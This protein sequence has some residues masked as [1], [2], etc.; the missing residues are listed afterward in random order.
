MGVPP[1]VGRVEVVVEY[2]RTWDLA[3]LPEYSVALDGAVQ[4]PSVSPAERRL[5]FDHHANCIRMVTSACQQV[6]DAICV[7]WDPSGWKVFVNDVDGDTALAVALARNPHWADDHAVHDLVHAVG[8]ID[9]HGPA[10][11]LPLRLSALVDRF[12]RTAMAPVAEVR[13]AGAYGTAHH[14]ALLD[15]CVAR[16]EARVA[17]TM[18]P[19]DTPPEHRSY[20]VSHR[21]EGW[22]MVTS[23]APV[24]DLVYR[25]GHDAAVAYQQL[26][27]GSYAYTVA[28]RSDL[29]D[30]DVP[31]VLAALCEL[32][33]GWGG[34]S[35]IG[36]APRNADGSRS[37]LTL[38]EVAEVVSRV[39]AGRRTRGPARP[40]DDHRP[41][42]GRSGGF[43]GSV[44]A[45]RTPEAGHQRA[46]R[47]PEPELAP[48]RSSG[49]GAVTGRGRGAVDP[50]EGVQPRF[51]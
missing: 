13:R 17:G 22:V 11:R 28:Q 41:L 33:P 37:R 38:Q 2:G 32:E 36:G 42:G 15:E 23:D 29:V 35:S 49:S 27:D 46:P 44:V 19:E 1:V 6:L 39:V 31:A 4:G 10:Y 8:R 25:D 40:P 7:G 50:V 21:G 16:I 12:H 26:P 9:A 3:E 24:F 45:A 5:S 14:V 30:F 51:G 34:G 20:A 18:P 48:P 43:D 47:A